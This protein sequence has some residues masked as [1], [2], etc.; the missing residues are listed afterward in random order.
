[1]V[2]RQQ[3]HQSLNQANPTGVQIDGLPS[4]CMV[5]ST[6]FDGDAAGGPVPTP[7]GSSCLLYNNLNAD[8]YGQM[9]SIFEG[10]KSL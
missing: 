2:S 4:T 9:Q 6:V 3:E 8:Q 5:L 1:M 7:C 10:L